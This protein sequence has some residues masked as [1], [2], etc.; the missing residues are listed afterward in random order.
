M[1]SAGYKH[2]IL[3]LLLLLPYPGIMQIRTSLDFSSGWGI[4]PSLEFL[5]HPI[6]FESASVSNLEYNIHFPIQQKTGFTLGFGGKYILNHASI[7]DLDFRTS[8]LRIT[9]HLLF[10]YRLSDKFKL[11]FGMSVQNNR[12][13]DDIQASQ[14]FNYRYNGLCRFSYFYK[15]R[16]TFFGLIS[17]S[18]KRFSDAYFLNDPLLTISLGVGFQLNKIE[19]DE[20]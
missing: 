11:S 2:R 19:N 12:N 9:T 5:G 4:N 3:I 15:A 6:K 13:L 1:K 8:T 14:P 10:Y 16:L 18:L 17:S 20:E 7:P